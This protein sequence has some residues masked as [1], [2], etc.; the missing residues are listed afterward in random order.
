MRASKPSDAV[1]VEEDA[2]HAA[3]FL[4]VLQVEIVVAPGLEAR[5]QIGAERLQRVLALLVEMHR[6]LGKAVIRRQ[7][8]AAAEPADLRRGARIAP[9]ACAH[10]CA[11]SA[12]RDC[13]D[14]TPA[15]RPGPRKVHRPVPGGSGW[16]M[17]A[18]WRRAHAKSHNRRAR[19]PALAPGSGCRPLPCN[20]SPAGFSQAS[21]TKAWPS[22]AT[23]ASQIRCC[24]P[25]RY[26]RTCATRSVATGAG[27]R[28]QC[29]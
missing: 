20:G 28:S 16:P 24:R 18:A 13:A 26:A 27:G 9:P 1:V 10:S 2:A 11:P 17:A 5:V 23:T 3:L 25:S 8:H 21:S 29:P 7:V 6:I 22:I 15:T 12:H 19:T 4:A 14:E